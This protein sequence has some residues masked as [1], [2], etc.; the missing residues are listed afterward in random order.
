MIRVHTESVIVSR[1]GWQVLHGSP[2]L[3]LLNISL[4]ASLFRIRG[5]GQLWKN[6]ALK[7]HRVEPEPTCFW[8]IRSYLL[9]LVSCRRRAVD[10]VTAFFRRQLE[11]ESVEIIVT[12]KFRGRPT[13]IRVFLQTFLKR[14][15]LAWTRGRHRPKLEA[16]TVKK[17]R[18]T[19]S[20]FGNL[21]ESGSSC[22]GS[23]MFKP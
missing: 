6:I 11:R 20:V 5:L 19:P 8:K 7:R 2:G 21:A 4:D 22:S 10:V 13:F 17:S 23:G 9:L 16:L 15:P 1:D 3:L 12:E 18:V 14:E